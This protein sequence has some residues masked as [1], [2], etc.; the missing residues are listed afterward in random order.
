ML[1][2]NGRLID[3]SQELDGLLDLRITDEKVSEIGENLQPI[4]GEEVI[5][6]QGLIVS[7]GFVDGH[8]HFRDPGFHYKEDIFSGSE[9]AA[10]GGYTSVICMANTNPVMDNLETLKYFTDKAKDSIINVYTISA[11][12]KGL[13]GEELVDM[14]AMI[15]NG[16]VGF[17]DDGIPNMNVEVVLEGIE[18][19][20]NLDVPISFHEEHPALNKL[21]GINEGK[22]SEKLGL[23]GAPNVSEDIMVA[24]DAALCHYTGG[25]I[26]IQHISSGNAVDIVRKY[27][28]MGAKLYAE[29]TPNH[30]SKTEEIVLEKGALGKINPPIRTE[31][32]RKEILKGLSDNTLEIIAT[33]HAPHSKE[34]KSGD[35]EKA[36]SGL[37]GLETSLSLG[38]TNLT[39]KG[40]LTINKLIEKMTINPARL[41]KLNAGTLKVGSFGD[42]TIFD[43]EE[44]YTVENFKSRSSN[45]PFIGE[46]LQGRV[47]YTIVK[48]KVIYSKGEIL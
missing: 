26:C 8:V 43:E 21:N 38:I 10:A 34:E 6:A 39:S 31:E 15:E 30:F 13:K 46:E 35:I 23:G 29:V 14:E 16:A 37:I 7:P 48:G 32:D 33:D 3:P 1:I 17:S 25:K 24:R 19:A 41:Y 4:N 36:M 11:L 2:K 20:K 28:K 9:A 40:V 42:I 12:T 44:V 45:S 27:K 18:R 22:V 5:D 47:K